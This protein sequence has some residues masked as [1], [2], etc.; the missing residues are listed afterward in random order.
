M[1]KLRLLIE[2]S[3]G[4]PLP[5]RLRMVVAQIKRT[6]LKKGGRETISDTGDKVGS[7]H[8]TLLQ[9]V[10]DGVQSLTADESIVSRPR[11]G[12]L[13]LLSRRYLQTRVSI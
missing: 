11:G 8:S 13:Y 7:I 9:V 2:I 4:V 1:H 3:K 6:E 10:S 5:F 12:W